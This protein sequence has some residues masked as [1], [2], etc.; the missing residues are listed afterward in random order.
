MTILVAGV[1]NIFL[2][3]DA[4]GCEVVRALAGRAVPDGVQITDFGI[5]GVHLAYQLLDGCDLLVLVDAAP[6]GND[7][8]TVSLLDVELDKI[9][10]TDGP[11]VDAHGMA[12]VPILSMLASLGGRVARVLVVAC[13]PESV[14]E[15]IGLS[16]VVSAAVPRAV[17]LVE[18]VITGVH[19][20]VKEVSN[21]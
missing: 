6:R 11:L 10:P 16:A 20:S 12:P 17:E 7:P 15:G 9:E 18:E 13:E 4:F 19:E 14:E 3:D 8:G 2:S 5:R 1:G 21:R